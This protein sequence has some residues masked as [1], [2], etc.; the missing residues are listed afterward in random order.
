MQG[1]GVIVAIFVIASG[2]VRAQE[3]APKP[4]APPP[5]TP[6]QAARTEIPTGGWWDDVFTER[7]V[8]L[9]KILASPEAWRDLPVSFGIQFRQPGKNGPSF[10]TRFEPDQW[11]NFAAWPD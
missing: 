4:E 6:P 5:P 2:M 8:P 7:S 9:G 11:L 3:Q 1:I 10:F